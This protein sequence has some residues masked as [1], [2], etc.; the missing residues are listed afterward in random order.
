MQSMKFYIS[1]QV[2]DLSTIKLVMQKV[3]EAGHVI[4]HDWTLSDTLLGKTKQKIKNPQ[5]SGLRAQQDINGVLT[6]DVFVLCSDNSIAG[7][8]MYAEL[9]A[10][11]ALHELVGTP[12]IYILG[13]LQHLS[14]FYL[15]PAVK[16]VSSIDQVIA[17][18]NSKPVV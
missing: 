6:S 3:T 11:L 9:G 8:G 1:G 13:K 16:H 5:D 18:L 15:H 2:G 4:T 10:A 14:I 12:K 7:K 17:D